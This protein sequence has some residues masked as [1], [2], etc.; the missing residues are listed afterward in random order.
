M[1]SSL[2]DRLEKLFRG[3]NANAES[4]GG[5]FQMAQVVGHDG[6]GGGVDGQL[7]HHVVG[8]IGREISVSPLDA[9]RFGYILEDG[10]EVC[11]LTRGEA[12]GLAVLRPSGDVAVLAAHF[13]IQAHCDFSGENQLED[14]G[15]CP[16][17]RAETRDDDR[18]IEHNSH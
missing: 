6:V 13:V 15:R 10:E 7:K 17:G 2:S 1:L 3:H 11:D 8:G 4:V 12:R 14:A 9:Y 18:G 5:L 16:G